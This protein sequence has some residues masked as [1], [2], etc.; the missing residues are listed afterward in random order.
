MLDE[1][2]GELAERRLDHQSGEADAFYR[3]LQGAGGTPIQATQVNV[4]RISGSRVRDPQTLW[5]SPR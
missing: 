4:L 3:N 2:T 5:R 1:T